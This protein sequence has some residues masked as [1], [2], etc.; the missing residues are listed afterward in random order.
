MSIS[1]AAYRIVTALLCAALATLLCWQQHRLPADLLSLLPQLPFILL[2]VALLIPL[3]SNHSKELA[4]SL[5]MLCAYWLIRN[6]LQAPLQTVPAAQI[7]Y[8]LCVV[9]PINVLALIWLPE[10][11]LRHP[12]GIAIALLPAIGLFLL[13]QLL[14]ANSGLMAD[15]SR[16]N[17]ASAIGSIHLS[18]LSAWL[19]GLAFACAIFSAIWQ[20]QMY[21]SSAVGCALILAITMGWIDVANISAIMF[22]GLGL[23]LTINITSGL[24]HIGFYDELTQIG[25]RRAL[26]AAAA[27]AKAKA[28]VAKAQAALPPAALPRLDR[29]SRRR[30]LQRWR[31]G[32]RRA[33]SWQSPMRSWQ[34]LSEAR[35]RRCWRG[36]R[37]AGGPTRRTREA[38]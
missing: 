36:S 13:A 23:L 31:R 37:A 6:H 32:G 19:Y 2:P 28:A 26:L 18:A 7:F 17:I 11:G 22:T 14:V 1:P 12:Q 16:T 38:A 33:V 25:N 5:L 9:L 4:T 35:R 24:F 29:E 15:T 3:F 10:H 8:L 20:Q 21:A 34:R 27:D 30:H